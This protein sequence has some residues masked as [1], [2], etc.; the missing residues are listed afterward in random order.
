MYSA[1]LNLGPWTGMLIGGVYFCFAGFLAACIWPT[2]FI[3][4][5]RIVSLDYKEWFIKAVTV[6]NNTSHLCGSDCLG[7][8]PSLAS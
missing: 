3:W 1:H 4:E 6:V 5:S 7:K 2:F 8:S